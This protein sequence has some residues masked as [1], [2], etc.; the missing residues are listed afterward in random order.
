MTHPNA[1]K[2]NAG[3]GSDIPQDLLSTSEH[4]NPKWIL[5]NAHRLLRSKYR[6]VPLW[7]FISELTG[8]GS[9]YSCQVAKE[10]GWDPC[11]DA[12]KPIVETL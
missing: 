11:Q 10:C 2:L 7:S 12:G 8:H 3:K 9:G 4:C 6:G 1:S 5:R